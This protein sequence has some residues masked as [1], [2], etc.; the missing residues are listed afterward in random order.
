M[1]RLTITADFDPGDTPNV[2]ERVTNLRGKVGALVVD[3]VRAQIEE[4]LHINPEWMGFDPGTYRPARV[5]R[6]TTALEGA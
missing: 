4:N 5:G 2:R 6:I 3:A 1:A